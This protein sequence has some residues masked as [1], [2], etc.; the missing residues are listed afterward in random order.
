MM[1]DEERQRKLQAGKAKLAEYR[2]RKA[3]S[4][5]QKKKK[6]KRKPELEPTEGESANT[7]FSVSKTLRS[8]ETVTHDQTYTIEPESEVSTT[9]E[10]CSSEVNGFHQR[11]DCDPA[12]SLIGEEDLHPSETEAQMEADLQ[13]GGTQNRMQIM[14]DELEAKNMAMEELSRELEDIRSTFGT[15]GVQQLQDFEEALKQR[16]EII[17]QL[18][19]NLQQARTEKEEVMREFLELTEQSQKLQIQFQQLQAGEILR[20]SN[21]SSTAADLLQA[22]T[23][24]T[25]YQQQLEER[26]A[27]LRTQQESA[28]TQITLNT[29]MQ[30]RL[31]RAETV[32]IQSEQSFTQSLREKDLLNMEHQRLIAEHTQ[33][34]TQLRDQLQTSKQELNEVNER[35]SAKTRALDN[36]EKELSASRQKERMSSGEILQLMKSVEDLQQRSH[37]DRRSETLSEEDWSRRLEQL[38]DE[39]DEMYGQQIT[40]M[41]Q[42]LR[43]QHAAEMQRM[44]DMQNSETEK[45]IL[46]HQAELER[47]RGQLYQS[48]GGVNVLNVKMIELQQ[49]LQ[50]TQVLREKAEQELTELREEKLHLLEKLERLNTDLQS[51]DQLRAAIRDL[52]MKLDEALEENTSINAEHESEVTN[53]KIKLDMLEREKDAVLDRMAESQ[54]AELE[55]LRTQLLFSH[56]EELTRLREDLQMENQLN[57]ENLRDEINTKHQ[58]TI[59]ELQN[60]LSDALKTIREK[61]SELQHQI[62]R[63]STENTHLHQEI[64]KQKNTFS[65]AERNFEVNYQELKEEYTCLANAKLQLEERLLKDSMQAKANGAVEKHSTELMEKLEKENKSLSERIIILERERAG[66]THHMHSFRCARADET[67]T[68]THTHTD[69]QDHPLAALPPQPLDRGHVQTDGVCVMQPLEMDGAEH[70]ECRLQLEAQRI[71]L[72]QIHAAQM[73]LLRESVCVQLRSREQT[74]THTHTQEESGARS[75]DLPSQQCSAQLHETHTQELHRLNTHSQTLMEETLQQSHS[76]PS[77]CA[78]LR[79]DL[80]QCVQ[81]EE[82]VSDAQRWSEVSDGVQDQQRRLEEHI[83]KVIVQMSVE[84]AQQTEHARISKQT[85]ETS[86]GMQTESSAEEEEHRWRSEKSPDQQ[87]EENAHHEDDDGDLSSALVQQEQEHTRVLDEL[88]NAH[89]HQLEMQQEQNTHLSAQIDTLQQRLLQTEQELQQMK[90]REDNREKQ[91]PF[92]SMQS[93]STQIEQ[94]RE[95]EEEVKGHGRSVTSSQPSGEEPELS[96]DDIITERDGLRLVNAGLRRVLMEVLKTTAAAEQTIGTHVEAILEASS[97]GQ[98]SAHNTDASSE[99][100]LSRDV[101]TDQ[102]SMFSAETESDEG[103]ETSLKAQGAELQL[104][105]AEL[106][107]EREEFQTS[108]STRLQSAVEKLLIAITETSTQL[109]HARITQTE[110]LREKFR[111]NEEMEELLRRQEELQERVCEEERA[112]E[113]LALELHRAEGLIDGYSDERRALEQQVCERADLQLHLEQELQVTST[114]LQELEQERCSLLEHTELMSRQRDAMRDSAGG[115]PELRLVEAALDAAPEADLLEETEKLLQEK[116]EV[117]RQAQKQS[118]E[119]QAQVKQLEAQLEEQQMRLQEQQELQRSQ[120]EDLQ[121]QIQALEKQT[122][123]HRRFIDEQAADREHERDVFQQEI[124]NLE[125]QL[126]NPTKTQT[127]SERRDREVQELSTALQEKS[128]RCSELLLSSERLQRDVKDREEEIQ[129]LAARVHQLE[130]TLMHGVQ[131][132]QHV[133]MAGRVDVTLEAQLQ[134]EREAL[135]RKEKEIV[136]L[137]EQ[138]EQFREELENKSEEVNQLNMQLQIQSKEISRYQQELQT[139]NT[140]TQVL[141]EKERQISVLNQ[142]I[143]KRQH[144]GTHPEQEAVE[145]KD[146]ALGEMEAL[147]ECLKSEQQRLKKDNEDEVEQLNAVIEKLQQELSHIEARDDHEEMKQR[148]EELTSESNTLRLQYEQLQEETR[149]HEEMR[150]KMEELTSESNTLR[151]QYEQLQEETRDHEEM[152]KKMEELTSES[153][154]LR[155]QYKQLQEETRDHEEMK[156]RMEEMKIECNSLNLQYKQL[157]EETK[158]HEEMKQRMEELTTESNTLRLQYEQLQA[159]TRD[160][161]QMKLKME[162]LTNESNTLQLQ[163]EQLQGVTRDHEEMKNMEELTTECN[164]LRLQY[165]QLQE[166]TRNYKEMK[167]RMEEL[168]NESNALRLQYEQ[169]QAKTGDQEEMKQKMEELT[170]ESNALRLQYEQWQVEM[171]DHEEMKKKMEE[172][173]TECNSLRLQ[174]EQL[175]EETRD[176][177]EMKKKIEELTNES[178][179]LRLQYEQLQEETRDQENIKLKM[180]EVT[181]ECNALRL[182]YEQLQEE[183]RDPEEMS[184]KMEVSNESNSLRLQYE[185]LQAEMKDHEKMKEKMEELTSECNSLHLQY[186]QLQME[187]R[188]HEEMKQKME[189]MTIERD[190]LRLQYEHLHQETLLELQETLREKTAASVVMQAQVQALEESA[191]ARVD[192]LSRRVEELQECVEEKDQELRACRMR[193]EQAQTDAHGLYDKVA[194]LEENL[195]EKVAAVLVSQAQL[196]AVQTQTKELHAEAIVGPRTQ[197]QEGLRM[198]KDLRTQEGLRT[199]ESFK[200]QESLTSQTGASGG[201]VNLLTEKLKELE[202]GLIVMQKDQELQKE[203]LCSSEEEVMEYESRLSVMMDLLSQM[204]T[205]T[206]ALRP[207]P[208]PEQS[209]EVRLEL[210]EVKGESASTEV[211]H[212]ISRLQEEIEMKESRIAQLQ[213][214]LREASSGP[215]GAAET[216]KLIQELQEVKGRAASTH[217]ELQEVKGQLEEVKGQSAH[218]EELLQD[219][220]MSLALLKDQLNRVSQDA[221]QP[222]AELLQELMEVRG[223]AAAASEDLNCCREKISQLQEEIQIRDA[224]IAEL[225]VKVQELQESSAQSSERQQPKNPAEGDAKGREHPG[226]DVR[227]HAGIDLQEHAGMDVREH[228]GTDVQ[229]HAGMDLQEHAG[230]DLQEHAGMD[231]QEH[232]C[233]LQQK[234]QQMQELHAAEIMDMETRHISE[235]ESLRREN[236]QLED[237]CRALRDA[238]H[239]LTHTQGPAVRSERP[240]VSPFKDGYTSDSS[241]DWS[242]RTGLDHTHLQQEMRSTPEGARRDAE[243]DVLPDRIK[244]LLRE[245]HQEGMQVLS[246]SELPLGEAERDTHTHAHTHTWSAERERDAFC[247]AVETLKSLI[248]RLQSDTQAAGDWRSELLSVVQQV[249]VRERELLKS[250]LFAHLERLDSADALIHLSQL[251]RALAEQDVRHREAMGVLCSADRSSLCS[252]IQQLRDQLHTLTSEH[253]HASGML[254]SD[255]LEEK[256][257]SSDRLEEK[258]LSSDRLEE[259]KTELN[260]TKLELESAL[261]TQH[262][263][264]RELDTLRSEVS[265]RV[266]EVDTLTDRLAEEQKRGRELQWALEKQ[267]HRLDRKEEADRE[268]VEELRLALEEQRSRVSEL[269]ISLE[270]QKQISDQQREV[271]HSDVSELQVQLDAQRARC[272]ELSGALEKEKQLNTQLIQRFQSGSTTHTLPSGTQNI[273]LEAEATCSQ[274]EAGVESV[275][276]LLQM[277]QSQL[278]EK[279][280]QVVQMMEE[281]E[282]QQ[283]EA[284]QHRRQSQ[285]ER[286][287]LARTAAEH[288]SALQT[289]CESLREMQSQLQAERENSRRMETEREK[290]QEMLILLEDR[291]HSHTAVKHDGQPADRTRDWVLQQEPADALNLQSTRVRETS[292]D[293]KHTEKSSD[294]KTWTTL[295]RLQLIAAKINSLTSQ[296]THRLPGEGPDQDSLVWLHSNVQDVMSLLQHIPSAPSALP[297]SASLLSAGSCSLLNE[298]LLRQN[299]ELTGFVSRLTEEKNELR[300]QI[301]K[302]EDELRRYRQNRDNTH[303]AWS[304]SAVGRQDLL[305]SSSERESWAQER[306]SLQKSLR[307]TEAELNRVRSELRSDTLRDLSSADLENTALKRMYGKYLRAESFRKAL[308]YQKKYLLLLLGGFQECEDA[309]L[310]LISHMGALPGHCSPHTLQRRGITRFRSAARVSIALSRMRFLV[311]R[312]QRASGGNTTPQILS[313][314]GLAHGTGADVRNESS[315]LSPAAVELF[316]DRRATSRGRTGRESPRS[317]ASVQH[318]FVSVPAEAGGLPCSHLQNYDPDRALTDYISRLEALQRRL[319]SVQSGSSSYAHFG[320]RR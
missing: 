195:R 245:V 27:Q 48:T 276:S 15:E 14:E 271:Q 291:L 105:E 231:L 95:H 206:S 225:R 50:E 272:T 160:Q 72:T 98:Q 97:K 190:S 55:R 317:A 7:V 157:Q 236:Q 316:R 42:E 39:L 31:S 311:K 88:R 169:L 5:G 269:S 58:Q 207:L 137:E 208:S 114:R 35:L 221:D 234:I 305:V 103:L 107:L 101:A 44:Q 152:R 304:R 144:T 308:I 224:S 294:P 239:T 220:E 21:I 53:Y 258:L 115:G 153:N 126:K 69:A 255:R 165:E 181:T 75:T 250:V 32:H 19:S 203:L 264:L 265:R 20:S 260:H 174:Y 138:L 91:H 6:K 241:S 86:T 270:Q 54:E 120:E 154:T 211:D 112:R 217:Q 163:N 177:K 141:E 74:H 315:F 194:Q 122:E 36:C 34:I 257:L 252:E 192:S 89:T 127:G 17:T 29:Q 303:T 150:K 70:A 214:A 51:S 121:Q 52:Q 275:E 249:F 320:V 293:P 60:Q 295:S 179:T 47:F 28:H 26:D 188:D 66:Q 279:Q 125:Q 71:S 132:V 11:S 299:A 87:T 30:E 201:K 244:N 77:V 82:C 63:L 296:S 67:H 38:R 213:A 148:M 197:L 43:L 161:E 227:E 133:S 232:I 129:T 186:K 1:E 130:H 81:D 171:R 233:G 314:N 312:W 131:E 274:V 40:Q 273:F 210:Q 146:E 240:A 134:T 216:P 307:Q 62:Q 280:T 140:L 10:D 237:E 73:E 180:E 94:Q 25:L 99:G 200:T 142:Q 92:P 300:N 284:L 230:I 253:T 110:L 297:E 242:Q 158:H 302:L 45:I 254:S 8:G 196:E 282:K 261:N 128:D 93:C 243:P 219:R 226:T 151:L 41:K 212:S 109:E 310:T 286:S 57:I 193:V 205:K 229:E 3:Q 65:F 187:T 292:A 167:Q 259:M 319:G 135:D 209:A 118:S 298:R 266:S 199:Q 102:L 185:Q 145:Q 139:H 159:E 248:S 251:E 175:Q 23:Q 204:R 85:H 162:E 124:F 309:T 68:H 246:L 301:L 106:Q 247:S 46:Q 84:F 9:A 170:N 104:Q 156:Q 281:M 238:I 288:Q 184:K 222:M 183:T 119:L 155:L 12:S 117:Q 164:S 318:R 289:A 182:Q 78:P 173:T 143:S 116:V 96:S 83:A 172:L 2:Q 218:L 176:H 80:L 136:N 18:T 277:L 147:V 149:D 166:E 178:D 22:R 287:A 268:E 189:E 113:Q 202:E 278:M 123:N 13:G 37:Q 283:L 59:H 313:R 33:T 263:H 306:I 64:E 168:T 290:L 4:D 198:Q 76:I 215:S 108:I 235:S 228:A 285:E 100:F 56:E 90:D 111:H 61:E 223:Q 79:A 49:K 262:T 24:I 16:D 267:K 191:A 256:L